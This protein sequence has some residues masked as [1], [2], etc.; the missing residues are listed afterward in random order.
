MNDLYCVIF[1]KK[2]GTGSDFVLVPRTLFD[3]NHDRNQL[4]TTLRPERDGEVWIL[5][6]D[7]PETE[8]I[9][10]NRTESPDTLEF[11][12]FYPSLHTWVVTWLIL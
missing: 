4:P 9:R 12:K 5:R 7:D 10:F 1:E 2:D 6:Y 3:D 8:V 11:F